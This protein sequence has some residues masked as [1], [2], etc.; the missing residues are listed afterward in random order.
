M[1]VSACSSN[2]SNNV[3]SIALPDARACPSHDKGGIS[4][5]NLFSRP[6]AVP[7]KMTVGTNFA[8]SKDRAKH[9]VTPVVDIMVADHAAMAIDEDPVPKARNKR[10]NSR[11]IP[12]IDHL[13]PEFSALPTDEDRVRA[14]DAAIADVYRQKAETNSLIKEH[15]RRRRTV[16]PTAC[17][18]LTRSREQPPLFFPP[19]TPRHAVNNDDDDEFE[20]LPDDEPDVVDEGCINQAIDKQLEISFAERERIGALLGE[21]FQDEE[22]ASR[23]LE[24]IKN[25]ESAKG[26][27]FEEATNE[28]CVDVHKL[29]AGLLLLLEQSCSPSE[30]IEPIEEPPKPAELPKPVEPLANFAPLS[31]R[32]RCPAVLPL[33]DASNRDHSHKRGRDTECITACRRDPPSS[34]KRST[35]HEHIR[36][37][38]AGE[39]SSSC[40]DVIRMARQKP[41]NNVKTAEKKLA[42]LRVQQPQNAALI[43]A[44]VKELE[45]RK[46]TLV[47]WKKRIAKI[48][49]QNLPFQKRIIAIARDVMK[50]LEEDRPIAVLK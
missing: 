14:L 40:L 35:L 13:V 19:S 5:E 42:K 38:E 16:R 46:E 49:Q 20:L 10:K 23:L 37:A 9:A 34:K 7:S 17:A 44:H 22:T 12:N 1:F 41:F 8:G 6:I 29:D 27:D 4:A 2:P 36:L 48:E 45:C 24:T 25:F 33:S 50:L 39:A 30:P 15:R 26:L 28:I 32:R 18:E 21:A 11:K 31:V 43:A 47:E 3:T